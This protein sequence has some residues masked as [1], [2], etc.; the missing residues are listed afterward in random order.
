MGAE[1]MDSESAGSWY[2]PPDPVWGMHTTTAARAAREALTNISLVEDILLEGWKRRI[3]FFYITRY[4]HSGK[5]FCI[6]LRVSHVLHVGAVVGS[7][8]GSGLAE[9][10]RVRPPFIGKR[11]GNDSLPGD[12]EEELEG[13]ICVFHNAHKHSVKN[14]RAYEKMMTADGER[15]KKTL[16]PTEEDERCFRRRSSVC[17][18]A[19]I[20]FP[21]FI[22]A[23]W[24]LHDLN[25]WTVSKYLADWFWSRM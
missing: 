1:R 2:A 21:L 24:F 5:H 4:T 6:T 18:C 8:V 14:G 19:Y 10:K 20:P 22:L 7:R 3:H 11:Y 9:A 25:G 17:A 23:C 16:K 15:E 12:R 13:G